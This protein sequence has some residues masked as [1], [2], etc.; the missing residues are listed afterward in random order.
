MSAESLMTSLGLSSSHRKDDIGESK[1]V[2]KYKPN[3]NYVIEPNES[4]LSDMKKLDNDSNTN[5]YRVYQTE[6]QI[7]RGD[8]L[9]LTKETEN[10]L[11]RER[12]VLGHKEKF[13]ELLEKRELNLPLL[14]D[15]E[16]ILASM[17]TEQVED[18]VTISIKNRAESQA[19]K[20]SMMDKIDELDKKSKN[21]L[22]DNSDNLLINRGGKLFLKFTAADSDLCQP[23]RRPKET[24][25]LIFVRMLTKSEKLIKLS[26]TPC[27]ELLKE[28][29]DCFNSSD[30]HYK[31][32]EVAI[33][34]I[35]NNMHTI[36]RFD[37]SQLTY[38]LL[39]PE[40]QLDYIACI[41]IVMKNPELKR[42]MEKLA[43]EK[44]REIIEARNKPKGEYKSTIGNNK[45]RG[46]GR[47]RAQVRG[48]NRQ[49]NYTRPQRQNNFY[50]GGRGRGNFR[51]RRGNFGYN[52]Y[53]QNNGYFNNNYNQNYNQ[54]SQQ[55]YPNQQTLNNNNNQQITNSPHNQE[56]QGN[57]GNSMRGGSSYRGGR[58]NSRQ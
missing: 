12:Q 48:Y 49:N 21:L 5:K 2:S 33:R 18:W 30:R 20:I 15:E 47:G 42:E 58:G 40:R 23:N 55:N 6:L 28:Y 31:K 35:E 13:V 43:S 8:L 19:R 51:A 39:T 7:M 50:R 27:L 26:L 17:T 34:R 57:L 10:L 4:D 3:N 37:L 22:N 53:R 25:G 32:F 41:T 45:N 1:I 24:V 29:R 56:T 36:S 46:R 38:D 54:N 44:D 16:V 9:R 11:I 52:K 14:A